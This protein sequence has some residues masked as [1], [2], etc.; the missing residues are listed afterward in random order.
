MTVQM[1]YFSN[2]WR[3]YSLWSSYPYDHNIPKFT[4]LRILSH[5][6]GKFKHM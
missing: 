4:L 2:Y 1:N 5:D 6:D 3:N